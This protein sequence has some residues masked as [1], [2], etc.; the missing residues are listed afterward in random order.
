MTKEILRCARAFS[1]DETKKMSMNCVKSCWDYSTT[2]CWVRRWRTCRE[3]NLMKWREIFERK[4]E[5]LLTDCLST[6][7]SRLWICIKLHKVSTTWNSQTWKLRKN[8]SGISLLNFELQSFKFFNFPIWR[9][10]WWLMATFNLTWNIDMNFIRAQTA[11]RQPSKPT[12][13]DTES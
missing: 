6:Q 13:T 9:S 8:L 5:T 4:R 11:S 10:S 7:D 1:N 2:T 12:P 3:I